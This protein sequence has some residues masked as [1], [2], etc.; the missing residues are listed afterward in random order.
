MSSSLSF[1]RSIQFDR[2]ELDAKSGQLRR[3]NLPVDLSPQLL[4]L[5]VMLAERPGELV[6]REE[7]KDAL[8]PEESYGD[9]DSRLNF[10]IKKLREA[11][12]DDAER[13]RFVQ[14][15]RRVGY[16]FI[17]T[18]REPEPR[19]SLLQDPSDHVEPKQGD[20][21]PEVTREISIQ[22]PGL[23]VGRNALFLA[24][25][26]VFIMAVAATFVLELRHR[27]PGQFAFFDGT[28]Q[29]S[30]KA[31][32]VP[33]IATV[34]P[35]LPQPRQRIVIKGRGFGLH[36]PYARTDSPYLAIRDKTAHWSAGRTIPQNWDE[37]MVDVE[38]WTDTEIVLSGFSGEYGRNGWSLTSGDLLE[39][40][41]WNPQSGVGPAI[42]R[43][44]VSANVP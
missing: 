20:T 15:V 8:W 31:E 18:V 28:A 6:S 36:V 2:F 17:A 33:E 27:G 19:V 4:R 29:P 22:R 44:G 37:V 1:R 34:T 30:A 41:V 26:A 25:M 43:V 32:S 7:I 38:G 11:L 5:L 42:Y 9:F 24:L 40:A 16:R 12:G 10:A 21:L 14:T 3:S 13:P 35:I 23:R 39:I